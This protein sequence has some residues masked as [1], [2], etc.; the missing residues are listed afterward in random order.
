MV[1]FGH[2]RVTNEHPVSTYRHLP[3]AGYMSFKFVRSLFPN[4]AL[5]RQPYP[6]PIPFIELQHLEDSIDIRFITADTIRSVQQGRCRDV[7]VDNVPLNT[8]DPRQ[9][10]IDPTTRNQRRPVLYQV[11]STDWGTGVILE[12]KD[13]FLVGPNRRDLHC[14]ALD[15]YAINH[16]TGLRGFDKDKDR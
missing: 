15:R 6:D 14:I 8:D 7:D 11:V 10:L 1:T 12:A 4:F 16:L 2:N 9:S 5:R 3:D 13:F